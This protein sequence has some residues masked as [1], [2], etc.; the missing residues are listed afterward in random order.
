MSDDN[1]DLFGQRVRDLAAELR[2][3]TPE[4]GR[5]YYDD[6][7]LVEL[8][9]AALAFLREISTGDGLRATVKVEWHTGCHCHGTS[10]DETLD[11]ASLDGLAAQL[12]AHGHADRDDLGKAVW[13]LSLSVTERGEM[14]DAYNRRVARREEIGR[15]EER[16]VEALRVYTL[17]TLT[18][19]TERAGLAAIRE[20]LNAV[21]LAK[22]ED[23]VRALEK[24][25]EQ[26]REALKAAEAAVV[27]CKA[28]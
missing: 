28:R 15:L 23:V 21:G 4:A 9:A 7:S 11:D 20:E 17:A 26:R 3:I 14:V 5:L 12:A 19:Q 18:L 16:V 1:D 24:N 25:V 2:A 27:A 13:T 6:E 10:H 8:R 22:R